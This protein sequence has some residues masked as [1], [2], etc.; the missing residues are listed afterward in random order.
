MLIVQSKNPNSEHCMSS[1][2]INIT[3]HLRVYFCSIIDFLAEIAVNDKTA[4]WNTK[5]LIYMYVCLHNIYTVVVCN[6]V[7]YINKNLKKV[8]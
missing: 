7:V 1:L 5:I 2:I 3:H 4:Y 8:N 6:E